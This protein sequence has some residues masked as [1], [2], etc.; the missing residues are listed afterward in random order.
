MQPT[1]RSTRT[2]PPQPN[3]NQLRRQAREL[4]DAFKAGEPGVSAEVHAHYRNAVPDTFALH[5]AQLVL[6]RAYGFDSW[7]RLKSHVDG[8]NAKDFISAVGADDID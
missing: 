2:L 4:L 6:A 7:P 8:I 1:T 5:D 3:L